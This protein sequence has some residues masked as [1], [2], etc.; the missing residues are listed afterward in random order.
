MRIASCA[1]RKAKPQGRQGTGAP[2]TPKTVR[3]QCRPLSVD[4]ETHRVTGPLPNLRW[5][6]SKLFQLKKILP[7]ESIPP[8]AE[9]DILNCHRNSRQ[10]QG[11]VDRK[12]K[13]K[14]R[15]SLRVA[16]NEDSQVVYPCETPLKIELRSAQATA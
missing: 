15:E 4:L 9:S 11:Q 3:V 16:K 10:A 13:Q 7:C 2:L 12:E 8:P 14:M 6:L 1:L 5:A